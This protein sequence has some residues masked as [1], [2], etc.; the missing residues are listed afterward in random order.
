MELRFVVVIPLLVM[1][2]AK[3]E[4]DGWFRRRRRRRWSP[5]PPQQCI[6]SGTNLLNTPWFFTDCDKLEL[7]VS[8]SPL[9]ILV[10][11]VTALCMSF[12]NVG[13]LLQTTRKC[14]SQSV[15]SSLDRLSQTVEIF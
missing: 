11:F 4:V 1:Y 5:P 9:L 10:S 12:K 15:V 2:F 6:V 13:Y 8:T 7:F 14:I 3:D